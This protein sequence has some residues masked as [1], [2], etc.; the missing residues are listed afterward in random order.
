MFEANTFRLAIAIR[1]Q[2]APDGRKAIIGPLALTATSFTD[3]YRIARWAIESESVSKNVLVCWI[4]ACDSFGP[5]LRLSIKA[6]AVCQSSRE[7]RQAT[8]I[9]QQ[10]LSSINRSMVSIGTHASSDSAA[11]AL[12][13]SP[14][15]AKR[16]T[17][18]SFSFPA[19]LPPQASAR[20]CS[21]SC[22]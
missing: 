2:R 7:A 6:L 16:L 11:T 19:L 12:L 15:M 20:R 14:R 1:H 10:S 5:P 3:P 22:G 4:C 13:C 21:P 8:T 18:E 9:P 17:L